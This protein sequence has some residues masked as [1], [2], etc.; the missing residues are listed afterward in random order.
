MFSKESL[1]RAFREIVLKCRVCPKCSQESNGPILWEG[2]INARV[3]VVARNSGRVEKE[4][5]RP[6]IGSGGKCLD[7]FLVKAGLVRENLLITNSCLCYTTNDR[8]PLPEELSN[9]LVILNKLIDLCSPRLILAFGKDAVYS[10]LGR[11]GE[12]YSPTHWHGKFVNRG[13]TPVMILS[14]PGQALRNPEVMAGL[15]SD[16]SILSTFIRQYRIF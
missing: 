16:A 3:L 8:Q 5:R 14:H 12:V 11:I 6:F 4:V 10:V 2:P 13:A 15:M 9:C 7:K 1:N